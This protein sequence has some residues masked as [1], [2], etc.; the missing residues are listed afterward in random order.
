MSSFWPRLLKIKVCLLLG[1]SCLIYSSK[2]RAESSYLPSYKK[3]IKLAPDLS[4][5]VALLATSAAECAVT[6][7]GLARPEK[8]AII[9]YSLPS[10]QKR[11]WLF[12][13][14][15][16]SLLLRDFVAHGKNSGEK[17]AQSFSNSL[18]SLQSSLGLFQVGDSY[19]GKHGNS[20]R[21]IG[22]EPGVNDLALE[23]AIVIHG[24]DYVSKDYIREH[25]RLGRSFGCPALAPDS[26][27]KVIEH[28]EDGNGLLFSYYPD[29]NWLKQ[30]N[31]L[32]GCSL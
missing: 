16:Q 3:L 12:D 25:N 23:R 13:L 21:L 22:L 9:D 31:F 4:S 28:F 18:G 24:A 8:I 30:S 19:I 14:E 26:A 17:M 1:T 10:T 20:L 2:L 29:R 5:N 27:E 32:N 7:S 11:F 15:D 6:K